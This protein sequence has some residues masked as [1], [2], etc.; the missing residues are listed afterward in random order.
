MT[1]EEAKQKIAELVKLLPLRLGIMARLLK[2]IDR[3]IDDTKEA[4]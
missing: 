3:I 1:K 4:E 2:E